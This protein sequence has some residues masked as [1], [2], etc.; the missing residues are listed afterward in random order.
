MYSNDGNSYTLD[1]WMRNGPI[2]SC[3]A[4]TEEVHYGR[5]NSDV[6]TCHY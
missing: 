4:L 1:I 3:E 2:Q 5:Y 6:R